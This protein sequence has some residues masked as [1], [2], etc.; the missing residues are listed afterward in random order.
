MLIWQIKAE[1]VIA[2]KSKI[3]LQIIFILDLYSLMYLEKSIANISVRTL[4]DMNF[5]ILIF[6]VIYL[7]TF[8]IIHFVLL[9]FFILVISFILSSIEENRRRS[10]NIEGIFGPL[11]NAWPRFSRWASTLY[12]FET[13]R[14]MKKDHVKWYCDNNP[15]DKLIAGALQNYEENKKDSEKE[16]SYAARMIVLSISILLFEIYGYETIFSLIIGSINVVYLP[17]DVVAILIITVLYF[18]KYMFHSLV[19]FVPKKCGLGNAVGLK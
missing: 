11:R 18:I 4:R 7:Y 19:V 1:D 16:L 5:E 9:L 17:Y 13:R 2:S 10:K 12:R 15:D 8:W 3:I 14:H 6:F